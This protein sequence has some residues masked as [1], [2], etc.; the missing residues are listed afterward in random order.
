MHTLLV[1]DGCL[2]VHRKELV[3]QSD[4][5]STFVHSCVDKFE[6]LDSASICKTLDKFLKMCVCSSLTEL[7]HCLLVG[8]VGMDCLLLE[9]E[10]GRE[11]RE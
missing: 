8:A 3:Y 5:M 11:R 1:Y 9:I 7:S 6:K 10:R 4:E 2:S